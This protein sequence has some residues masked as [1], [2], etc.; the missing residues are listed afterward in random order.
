MIVLGTWTFEHEAVE[1]RELVRV[2][3]ERAAATRQGRAEIGAR[4]VEHRHEVVAD[5]GDAAGGEIAQ[6]L[7]VIVEEWLEV[8]L[9]ELD[10]LGHGQALHDA[11]AQAERGV[12][13]DQRLSPLDLLLRPDDAVGDLVQRGDDAA[14]PGLPCIGE[15]D[16]IVRAEPTPSLFHRPTL[17]SVLVRTGRLTR[18]E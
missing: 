5:G 2:E 13:F 10:R 3:A 4:P 7:A 1:C 12:G 9:A 17:T 8:A 6:R 16:H 14:C 15:P 18:H 11:P